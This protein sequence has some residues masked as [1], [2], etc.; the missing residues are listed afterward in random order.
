VWG[1]RRG[2][3]TWAGSTLWPRGGGAR[4][5]RGAVQEMEDG[6]ETT[7]DVEEGE[8]AEHGEET[9]KREIGLHLFLNDFGG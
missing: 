1:R 2:A 6:E 3:G 4:D 9:A 5:G 8:E 7:P